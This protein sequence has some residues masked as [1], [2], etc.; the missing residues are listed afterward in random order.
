MLWKFSPRESFSTHDCIFVIPEESPAVT[1]PITVIT[2]FVTTVPLAGDVTMTL[3]GAGGGGGGGGGGGPITIIPSEKPLA[4]KNSKK[5]PLKK[6]LRKCFEF[7]TFSILIRVYSPCQI[8]PKSP[9]PRNRIY[10]PS[11]FDVSPPKLP[12]A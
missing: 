10:S 3:G 6:I 11:M 1:V 8:I 4:T 9:D 12:N 7:T 2:G 5:S